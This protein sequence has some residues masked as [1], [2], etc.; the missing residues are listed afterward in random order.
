MEGAVIEGRRREILQ[1]DLQDDNLRDK[2]TH[3]QDL[4]QLQCIN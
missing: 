2:T 4:S 3:K 1:E